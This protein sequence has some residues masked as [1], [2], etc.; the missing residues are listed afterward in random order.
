MKRVFLIVLDSVGIGEMPDA[1]DYGDA[2]SNTLKAVSKS[3]Y[4]SMPNM[5]K[6]GY[7]NIDGVDIGEKEKAPLGSFARMTE[8]SKGKDT[9]IGHWEI[10]GVISPTPL[11]TY[12]NGFPQEILDEFSKRTGRGV[13]CNKPYSG[14]DVI[15][16]YGE[17]HMKTGDLIV[18]TSADSVFQVAA[19]EDVVPVEQLYEYC[20]IAREMLQGEHGV[21]RVIARPFIG[22]PG[23]FTR[24]S[25]RHDF[26]LQPPKVTMLD[27]LKDAGFDVLSVGK[28]IDIFAEKGITEYVRSDG[29]ADGIDK[30]LAYMK[31]DFNGL[32]FTNLV[33]YDMLYGHRNDVEGYAK[34]LTYFDERLPEL[35]AQMKDEDILMI[36]AD[37]GCDPS[38][39]STDHS[40]EYTPLLMYGKP[41]KA[42]VN[43]G[44]RECFA[45]TAATILN[46][47]GIKP[48][49]AGK[50]II[51]F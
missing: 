13:L 16:D 17:E 35:L 26:S 41:I 19:H 24:T 36:T 4:F 42:G 7:F 32:C 45:D 34:A 40:R 20:K 47:F 25:R 49:C 44:T 1:A 37:H 15:R 14:T 51:E 43:Y 2:G 10:A 38:T 18:Y 31:K 27:Q 29:N 23:N 22:T 21:G 6:L 33:D 5:R 50:T 39:P 30:T 28:I 12:P 46:Y 3:P 48:E 9:T 8:V 11:P